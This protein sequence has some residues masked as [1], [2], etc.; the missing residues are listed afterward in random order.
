MCYHVMAQEHKRIAD[1]Y[2]IAFEKAVKSKKAD[3][4]R[5]LYH[6]NAVPL[7][8]TLKTKNGSQYFFKS[9][10]GGWA[11]TV[12]NQ[13]QQPYELRISDE[14]FTLFGGYAVSTARFDEYLDEQHTADGY[15][16]FTYA[17]TTNG[18]RIAHMDVTLA[19][20]PAQLPEV[21]KTANNKEALTGLIENMTNGLKNCD[22]SLVKFMEV[23]NHLSVN[24]FKN[25]KITTSSKYD[26]SDCSTIKEKEG[27]NFSNILFSKPRIVDGYMAFASASFDQGTIV[28]TSI[29]QAGTWYVSS[30]AI[31]INT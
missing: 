2:P 21:E 3:A 30:F 17:K 4:I 22:L 11:A 29:N 5:A 13:I 6:D 23:K 20:D 9:T 24:R 1:V 18:W 12:E 10:A 26:R 28:F 31:N 25:E 27:V 15:D 16:L 7:N 19:Q 14:T 8:V